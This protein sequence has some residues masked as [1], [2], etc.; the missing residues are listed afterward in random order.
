MDQC[1][2]MSMYLAYE[3]QRL[4]QLR[5]L[6]IAAPQRHRKFSIAGENR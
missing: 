1:A 4:L 2:A 5:S 3:M 6:A